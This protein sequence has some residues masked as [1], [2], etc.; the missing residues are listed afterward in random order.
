MKLGCAASVGAALLRHGCQLSDTGCGLPDTLDCYS[1]E[2]HLLAHGGGAFS[3]KDPAQGPEE[4]L[5]AHSGGAFTGKDPAKVERS[6]ACICWQMAKSVVKVG[7]AAC[8]RAAL[9]S[10]F[11]WT[12]APSRARIRPRSRGRSPSLS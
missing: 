12:V 3:G 7:R 1:P 8:V 6:A 4:H 10:H 9:C 11:G 5:L 2:V